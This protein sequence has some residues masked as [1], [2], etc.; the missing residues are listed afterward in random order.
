MILRFELWIAQ[1]D[2]TITVFYDLEEDEGDHA[3]NSVIDDARRVAELPK[4]ITCEVLK[5]IRP[6]LLHKLTNSLQE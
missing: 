3:D 4:R 5:A 2:E 1:L 6:E